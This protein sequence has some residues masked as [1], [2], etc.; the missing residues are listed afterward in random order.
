MEMTAVNQYIANV[1]FER[2]PLQKCC[3]CFHSGI[4]QDTLVLL[5]Q[6]PLSVLAYLN[7]TRFVKWS[8]SWLTGVKDRLKL[9]RGPQFLQAFKVRRV[10]A[11]TF[12][13]A[14]TIIILVSF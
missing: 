14:V 9:A 13:E 5:M 7:P 10:P 2:F 12:H 4:G 1:L 11:S 3:A 8:L 6:R